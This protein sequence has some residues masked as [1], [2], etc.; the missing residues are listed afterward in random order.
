MIRQELFHSGQHLGLVGD[1]NGRA[2][3]PG[4]GLK[5]ARI[6]KFQANVVPLPNMHHHNAPVADLGVE[7]RRAKANKTVIAD[8]SRAVDQH[9]V[10]NAGIVADARC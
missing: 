2:T 6:G 5:S 9:H 3:L 1:R 7:Y 4:T 10:G 8:V